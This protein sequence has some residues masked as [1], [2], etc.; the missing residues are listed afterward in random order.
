MYKKNKQR[1]TNSEVYISEALLQL[2]KIKS[3]NDISI[4]EVCEKA[5]V[6]RLTFYRHFHNLRDVLD[7]SFKILSQDFIPIY[8]FLPDRYSVFQSFFN[9]W[10]E[11]KDFLLILIH[12]NMLEDLLGY[13]MNDT[14][15]WFKSQKSRTSDLYLHNFYAMSSLSLLYTWAKHEFQESPNELAK[16]AS[17][18]YENVPMT[19]NYNE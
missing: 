19:L 3:Y 12:Q 9:K 14:Y 17:T 15:N 11:H 8:D 4:T 16:I 10:Y 18:L 2:M 5:G 13:F 7:F 6:S 1:K